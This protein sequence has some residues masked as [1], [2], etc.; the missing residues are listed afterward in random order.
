MVRRSQYRSVPKH[1]APQYEK[2]AEALYRS[3]ED[4]HTL[5]GEGGRYGNAIGVLAVHAAIAWTDALTIRHRAKKHTG[6]DHS[7]A[8]D[9]LLESLRH[10]V[11]SDIRKK[12]AAILQTKEEVSYQGEY[13]RVQDAM[14]LLTQLRAFREWAR[15]EYERLPG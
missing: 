1:R 11:P 6:S 8:A 14:I 13:Y 10:R 3:A 9:F 4:L 7:K 15:G 12:L 2:V 5:A